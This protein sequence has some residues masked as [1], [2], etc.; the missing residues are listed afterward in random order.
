MHEKLIDELCRACKA[1]AEAGV[2]VAAVAV[3]YDGPNA[4]FTTCLHLH[5]EEHEQD[6][7]IL[8]VIRELSVEWSNARHEGQLVWQE[9]PAESNP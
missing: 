9:P 5:G 8:D 4:D 2:N 1:L 6:H 7:C 3:A